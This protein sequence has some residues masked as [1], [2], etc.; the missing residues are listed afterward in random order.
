MNLDNLKHFVVTLEHG[1][2]TAAAKALNIPKSSLSRHLSQLEA[3]LKLK[4][5]DRRPRN[6]KATE[7]GQQLYEQVAPLISGLIEAEENLE[8]LRSIPKGP[9]SIQAPSEF[10]SEDMAQLCVEF[11]QEFPD[12][13]L[14][15]TQYNGQL[16]EDFHQTDVCFVLHD[17]P[18]PNI[19]SIARPLITF[20]QSIYC[21]AHCT[22]VT[23]TPNF[24]TLQN[25]R[26]ILQANEDYWYFRA[27]DNQRLAIPVKSSVTMNSQAMRM[28]ACIRGLGLAKLPDY[29]VENFVRSGAMKSISLP[30]PLSALTLSVLYRHRQVPRKVQVFVEFVQSSMGRLQSY[31]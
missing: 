20:P 25:A 18:L 30:K 13:Q 29:A 19:D 22:Q 5:I 1:S 28:H 6:L 26:L 23:D 8:D 27:E 12:I 17:A 16:P 31:L 7:A 4:L 24:D 2:V 3:E 21:S 11:L 9:L 14:C 10:I 15:F